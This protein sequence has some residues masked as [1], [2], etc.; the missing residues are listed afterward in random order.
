MFGVQLGH[1][2]SIYEETSFALGVLSD[3]L[4]TDP[5]ENQICSESF[6]INR[7]QTVKYMLRK[8]KTGLPVFLPCVPILPSYNGRFPF[9]GSFYSFIQLATHE[10][11]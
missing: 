3:S 2:S 9:N 8:S 5:N 4:D 7:F 10:A 6:A 11:L 1:Q